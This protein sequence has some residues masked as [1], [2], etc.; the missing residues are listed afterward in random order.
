[1][2]EGLF[3]LLIPRVLSI[4]TTPTLDAF[5]YTRNFSD[6]IH[7]KFVVV[8]KIAISLSNFYSPKYIHDSIE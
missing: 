8:K 7:S 4:V 5:I 1:M 2:K 6:A 3:H